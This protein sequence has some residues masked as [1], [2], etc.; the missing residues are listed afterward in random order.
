MCNCDLRHPYCLV[1]LLF[2]GAFEASELFVPQG[3]LFRVRYGSTGVDSNP[4]SMKLLDL[5]FG[6][7]RLCCARPPSLFT[8]LLPYIDWCPYQVLILSFRGLLSLS[9]LIFRSSISTLISLI[10]SFNSFLWRV[11]LIPCTLMRE[12]L[13]ERKPS[14]PLSYSLFVRNSL[15]LVVV[16][17]SLKFLFRLIA[18]YLFPYRC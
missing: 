14:L 2:L 4:P 18:S 16:L 7:G 13:H 9:Q 10:R 12:V 6:T 5:G 15:A 8:L 11:L 17:L 1:V 3:R